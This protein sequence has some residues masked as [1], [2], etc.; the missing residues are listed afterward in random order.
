VWW[1]ALM[2]LAVACVLAVGVGVAA[3]R[4]RTPPPLHRVT[5]SHQA[6][7]GA[8]RHRRGGALLPVAGLRA[9][10]HADHLPMY[11]PGRGGRT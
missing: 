10:E 3:Y 9:R 6:A 5:G 7:P 4:A 11:P 8:G 2:L 1:A